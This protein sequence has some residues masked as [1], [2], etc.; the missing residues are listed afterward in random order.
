MNATADVN[1]WNGDDGV[2]YPDLV[3]WSCGKAATVANI[4]DQGGSLLVK[5][6]GQC[7]SDA[8]EAIYR[9][10]LEEK[11]KPHKPIDIYPSA[12]DYAKLMRADS[13]DDGYPD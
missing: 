1:Q 10:I 5:L 3:C 12:E 11:T 4:P 13:D 2:P 8:L 7:L 9:A 6:C